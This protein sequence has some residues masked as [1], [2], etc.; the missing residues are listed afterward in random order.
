M[1]WGSG[2]GISPKAVADYMERSRAA[3]AMSFRLENGAQW[4]NRTFT[5]VHLERYPDELY[6]T[7]V[8]PLVAYLASMW[9][10]DQM[11]AA[12]AATDHERAMLRSEV[13]D[14]FRVIV[15]ERMAANGVVRI[16]KE[17]G[18]FVAR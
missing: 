10:V 3:G 8:E 5:D 13:M 2:S 11:V 6:V 9:S 12:A 15:E 7:E 1:L 18:A 4:L 17:T 16:A 14:S